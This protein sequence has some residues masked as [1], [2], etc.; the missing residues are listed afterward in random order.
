MNLQVTQENLSK[1]LNTVARVATSKTTL[2]ILSNVLLKVVGNRLSLSAT[3]LDIAI[4]QF[5]GSK[6][7]KEGSITLPA[8]LTQDFINNLP[9][10]TIDIIQQDHKI[11]IKTESY[12]STI[13]GVAADEFPVMPDIQEGVS[14]SIPA[15]DLKKALSRVVLAASTDEARPVLTGVCLKTNDKLLIASTDSYRLAEAALTAPSEKLDLLVPASA[16]QEVIRIIADYSGEVTITHDDQQ[17]LFTIEDVQLVARLID[18]QYPDYQKLIPMKFSNKATVDKAELTNIVK[19]ASLFARESAGSITLKT[20]EKEKAVTVH[21]IASQL[22]ENSASTPAK[23]TGDGEVTLNSR[24]ILEAI[25]AF[26]GSDV[27]ICFNGKL[28]PVVFRDPQDE[29]YRHLIM[30][31]KS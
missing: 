30:P 16:I 31:L 3:N 2:P 29:T 4:T 23:V 6:V 26:Y 15:Q 1:A 27:E 19:V 10:G 11:Q 22:G 25:Q 5:I 9:S 20:S 12:E 21:S 18:G 14:W 17:V 24:Y 7:T 13:N 28:E 8:R